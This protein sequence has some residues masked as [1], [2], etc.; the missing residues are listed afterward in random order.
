MWETRERLG[1][2]TWRNAMG[3]GS[4]IFLVI[5]TLGW[6][7]FQF[8]N[9]KYYFGIYGGSRGCGAFENWKVR[10]YV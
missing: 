9:F 8:L 1:M 10:G 5:V 2:N 4:N 7:L 6:G 3:G